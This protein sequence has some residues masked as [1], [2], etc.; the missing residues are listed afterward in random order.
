MRLQS[1]EKI[2][3]LRRRLYEMTEGGHQPNEHIAILAEISSELPNTI[4]V[5]ETKRDLK[6][7]TCGMHAFGLFED[8]AKYKAVAE[9]GL[10]DIYAGLKFVDWLAASRLVEIGKP[11]ENDLVIYFDDGG[12]A[13]HVGFVGSTGRVISK[14]GRGLL[15]EHGFSEV[16]ESYGNE[17][18]FFRSIGPDMALEHF[19]DYA[20]EKGAFED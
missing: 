15:Y 17:V 10:P 19:L 16:P 6:R 3:R 7:F 13:H 4:R 5:I 2:M 8:V 1:D 11:S 18:R 12:C 20:K 9:H 14:W